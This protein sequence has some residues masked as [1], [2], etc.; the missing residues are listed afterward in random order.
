MKKLLSIMLLACFMAISV[1]AA[2]PTKAK[3]APAKPP[4]KA[5]VIT[6]VKDAAA[7]GF[8]WGLGRE[9]AKETVKGV[10]GVYNKATG[11]DKPATPATV[12]AKK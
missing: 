2:P 5:G 8:G 6:K 3:K 12:P 11:S 7:R 1:L 4:K 10:K 9:A